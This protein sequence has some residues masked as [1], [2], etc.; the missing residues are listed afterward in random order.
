MP[1]MY[2]SGQAL[3]LVCF[4]VGEEVQNM[5]ISCDDLRDYHL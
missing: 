3:F 2:S 5:A 1:Y 4:S